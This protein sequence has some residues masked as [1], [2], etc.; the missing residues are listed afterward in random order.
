MI[1]MTGPSPNLLC[2]SRL[3][4]QRKLMFQFKGHQAGRAKAADEV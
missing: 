1:I 4:T 2:V 3:K